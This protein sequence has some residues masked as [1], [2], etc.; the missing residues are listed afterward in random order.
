MRWIRKASKQRLIAQGEKLIVPDKIGQGMFFPG[1]Y[2]IIDEL[3]VIYDIFRHIRESKSNL[4]LLFSPDYRKDTVANETIA[5]YPH[6]LRRKI[7]SGTQI[8]YK[9]VPDCRLIGKHS[10]LTDDF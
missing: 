7:E 2:R 6:I 10:G 1:R 9:N 8:R 5:I 4:T 3:D